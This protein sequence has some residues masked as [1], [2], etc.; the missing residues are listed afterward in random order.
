MFIYV[1]THPVFLNSKSMPKFAA[2]V[3][4]CLAQGGWEYRL[5]TARPCSGNYCRRAIR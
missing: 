3:S 2:V 1:L 4:D 5:I